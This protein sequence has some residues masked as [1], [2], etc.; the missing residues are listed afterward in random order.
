MSLR[1]AP[2]IWTPRESLRQR[3]QYARGRY[4]SSNTARR[5]LARRHRSAPTDQQ[6]RQD[7]RAPK[8]RRAIVDAASALGAAARGRI[9]GE[10]CT[11]Q[12]HGD[13]PQRLAITTPE[14]RRARTPISHSPC[15][16]HDVPLRAP[17]PQR[18]PPRATCRRAV[19]R[20][21][22]KTLPFYMT[23]CEPVS[24][25]APIV[26]GLACAHGCCRPISQFAPIRLSRPVWTSL[27]TT[28][29]G[30]IS[31]SSSSCT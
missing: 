6:A 25:S 31:T 8:L 10:H 30:P 20:S 11:G 15:A 16:S 21:S 23:R 27:R 17:Q 3:H 14:G 19:S 5:A 22:R 9:I 26:S 29:N 4:A 13:F 12:S 18:V 28:Q 1:C 24:T 7:R 2:Q